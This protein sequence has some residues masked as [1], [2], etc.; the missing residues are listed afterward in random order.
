MHSTLTQLNGRRAACIIRIKTCV[1]DHLLI[2]KQEGS[3]ASL[4]MRKK[5]SPGLD[6]VSVGSI[7]ADER[8]PRVSVGSGEPRRLCG[9]GVDS[10]LWN[11]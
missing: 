2:D 9:A 4:R 8:G 11:R 5:T 3:R 6:G 1:P 10:V 7:F